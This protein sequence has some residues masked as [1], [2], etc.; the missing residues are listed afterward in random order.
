LIA[1][2]TRLTTIQLVLRALAHEAESARAAKVKRLLFNPIDDRNV[3]D[4]VKYKLWPRRK[5]RD[6]WLTPAW[7]R[8][9]DHPTMDQVTY[10]ARRRHPASVRCDVGCEAGRRVASLPPPGA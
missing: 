8:N 4:N 3:A 10:G 6:S 7:M 1:S 9:E 5:D 2:A